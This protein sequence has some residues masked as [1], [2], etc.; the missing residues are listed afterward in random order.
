MN[1]RERELR[2]RLLATF[3]VEAEEHVSALYDQLMKLERATSP[4]E[5]APIIESA[6]REVHSLKGAARAVNI[7]SIERVCQGMESVF[8][9][10]KRNTLQVT[11]PLLDVLMRATRLVQQLKTSNESP[12]SAPAIAIAPMLTALSDGLQGRLP[13]TNP[14]TA[15]APPP[16]PA[17]DPPK[18]ATGPLAI[19]APSREVERPTMETVRVATETLDAVRQQTEELVAEKAALTRLAT[20]LSDLHAIV[21]AWRKQWS[22]ASG[23]LR[24]GPV[25]WSEERLRE[26]LD[27][28]GAFADR[29]HTGIGNIA[30]MANQSQRSFSA[31]A[32]G[33][34][35]DSRKLLMLPCSWLMDGLRHIVRDL[36]RDLGKDIDFSVAGGD[37]EIDRR[38]LVELKDPFVHILRNCLDHGIETPAERSRAGKAT[39]GKITVSI[40]RTPGSRIAIRVADDGRGIDTSKV[41][42]A[43]TKV[44]AMSSDE[45]SHQSAREAM[46]LI[47]RSDVSTSPM[48]TDVSGRGL[49]LAIVR[50]KVEA[51]GG[52]VSV[53]SQLG[54]G[55]TL[56]LALPNSLATFRGVVVRLGAYFFVVPTAN[57]ERAV[58]VSP[59]EI[60]SVEHR[61]I[62]HL[63]GDALPIV[64]LSAA[65]GFAQRATPSDPLA[66]MPALLVVSGHLRLVIV[67]DEIWQEQVVLVKSLGPHL[68][69]LPALTGATLLGNGKVAPVLD[70]PELLRAAV[71]SAEAGSVIA[72]APK[73]QEQTKRSILVAEDSI[74]SRTLL[75]GILESSGYAVETVVDG[76][77]ALAKLRVGRF[78]LVVSDVDMPRMN[79]LVLTSKIRADK[80]L[81][82]L[83]VVLVTSLESREDRE[84]G[85]EVGASAYI[86]KR[87]FEQSNLLEVIR[88]L[89]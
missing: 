8:A 30:R 4:E 77:E 79:G 70:G 7:D 35:D 17:P 65:L 69:R 52:T 46:N 11:P 80:N 82:D 34:A 12:A 28:N 10:M 31:K 38:I 24:G 63:S 6:F 86:V 64:R 33:L 42:A 62:V 14:A 22:Q 72:S 26:F 40:V 78:D 57:V 61:E 49:G 53:D 83:P 18:P 16:R 21:S 50:Q 41:R 85:V 68:R 58:R 89:L 51:L 84:R 20:E 39:R 48:I 9:A 37:I 75:R 59:A 1:D 88:R 73:T 43:A 13:A 44:G 15:D 81:A 29:L 36:G 23:E 74:T 47:F 56:T 76:V 71:R 60:R 66:K 67:V 27:A 87:N 25:S 55:A 54:G 19:A 3:G 45:L 5:I 2:N 32:D